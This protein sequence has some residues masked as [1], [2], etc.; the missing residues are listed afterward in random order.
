MSRPV[1]TPEILRCLRSDGF[2]PEAGAQYAERIAAAA[3]LN[4][5]AEPGDAEAYAEAARI[6]RTLTH[7]KPCT[8]STPPPSAAP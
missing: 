6:L 2:S 7:H 4:P 3:R 8:S 5:F 1:S